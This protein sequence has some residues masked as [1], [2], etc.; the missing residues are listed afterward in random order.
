MA[1]PLCVE[2]GLLKKL[3]KMPLSFAS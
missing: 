2:A 3:I 1:A